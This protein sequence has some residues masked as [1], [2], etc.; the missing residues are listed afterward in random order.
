LVFLTGDAMGMAKARAGRALVRVKQGFLVVFLGVTAVA[1][2]GI[3]GLQ[4]TESWRGS[5]ELIDA[6][7]GMGILLLGSFA[8]FASFN[9]KWLRPVAVAGWLAAGIM[10][11]VLPAW[12]GFEH[13]HGR[14]WSYGSLLIEQI[15]AS[16]MVVACMVC[17]IPVVLLPRLGYLG[18]LVQM[19]SAVLFATGGAICL[20]MIW[21]WI[22]FSPSWEA[23]LQAACV[24]GT[25]GALSAFATGKLSALKAQDPMTDIAT[26]MRVFCP[27][28]GR[29][30]E[31]GM[32]DSACTGCKLW[33][34]IEMEEPRCENCGYNLHKLEAERCPEC[35][36]TVGPRRAAAV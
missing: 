30:Q 27:R 10:L 28:C 14:G 12:A 31:V 34:V 5:S 16:G 35:G 2:V 6:A 1:A 36:W 20:A 3:V 21:D 26:T 7:M 32:G 17:Y 33:F 25:A 13:F 24:A 4:M 15:V 22:G 19:A 18:R 23:V 8:A 29:D 9:R 11:L